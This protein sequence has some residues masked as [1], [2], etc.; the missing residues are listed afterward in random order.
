MPLPCPKGQKRCTALSRKGGDCPKVMSLHDD[1]VLCTVHRT[2]C[3]EDPCEVCSLWSDSRWDQAVSS[4]YATRKARRLSR[5]ASEAGSNKRHHSASSDDSRARGSQDAGRSRPPRAQP[6][7]P[8]A[9]YRDSRRP[10]SSRTSESRTSSRSRD[11]RRPLP[12]PAGS[13]KSARH[14]DRDEQFLKR[15][16]D[17]IRGR[18]RDQEASRHDQLPGSSRQDQS[19]RPGHD[20]LPGSD[21]RP[22]SKI[23]RQSP[24]Q[25]PGRSSRPGRD[26]GSNR[27]PA[28]VSRQASPGQSDHDHSDVRAKVVKS[29]R[30]PPA[31]ASATRDLPAA[32]AHHT[33]PAESVRPRT[34]SVPLNIPLEHHISDSDASASPSPVRLPQD[35][36]ACGTSQV[37]T[38]ARQQQRREAATLRHR[39][40]SS[41][42]S[43][44]PSREQ[45]KQ[46]PP[47]E[48]SFLEVQQRFSSLTSGLAAS[49]TEQPSSPYQ[50]NLFPT[51]R[52]SPTVRHSVVRDPYHDVGRLFY[53]RDMDQRQTGRVYEAADRKRKQTLAAKLR[54][55]PRSPGPRRA[56]FSPRVRQVDPVDT[57]CIDSP[58]PSPRRKRSPPSSPS[59]SLSPTVLMDLDRSQDTADEFFRPPLHRS[60][61]AESV[62]PEGLIPYRERLG[63]VRATFKDT[64][65]IR[66]NPMKT[67]PT[68]RPV[69]VGVKVPPQLPTP[70][71]P[72]A[73]S[74]AGLWD[75]LQS[76]LEGQAAT[77]DATA[78]PPLPTGSFPRRP[79]FR[80]DLFRATDQPALSTASVPE[81]FSRLQR[82]R[83]DRLPYT[84]D[85]NDVL[86]WER[87]LRQMSSISSM[88]DW[89]IGTCMTLLQELQSEQEPDSPLTPRLN[90]MFSL[91]FSASTACSASQQAQISLLASAILRRRD[92]MLASLH[93]RVPAATRSR[94]RT[95][96]LAAH[97]LFDPVLCQEAKDELD[98][99]RKAAR[100]TLRP[101][102]QRHLPSTLTST[103]PAA[104]TLAAS[105]PERLPRPHSIPS[106]SSR[107]KEGG[108]EH[109]A[110]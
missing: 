30:R 46:Q 88:M 98:S 73:P 71:L 32:R 48:P 37:V 40:A 68:T 12:A 42:P 62:E 26:P 53:E 17:H 25:S 23:P 107:D 18:I 56:V 109:I 31:A 21:R 39:I 75:Q 110:E 99:V 80:A 85:S 70:S 52:S 105:S 51:G 28:R 49:R 61:L 59:E 13:D 2:C 92:S 96:E 104:R 97:T 6:A 27:L 20:V 60:P 47:P 54:P 102:R 94:L 108:E 58:S 7:P 33:P 9:S 67:V 81:V 91:L 82:R 38:K 100:E 1:H 14:H 74:R 19:P 36:V 50:T 10:S 35:T 29:K 69:G 90:Q 77:D 5:D 3:R 72:F 83:A 57:I 66:D 22:A 84:L 63:L 44:P 16:D 101:D 24:R 76:T 86:D 93:P 8:A 45:R 55:T 65:E 79:D 106:E 78:V 64:A 34:S 103:S 15:R 95:S 87:R 41:S 89:L 4:S 43:P 11:D